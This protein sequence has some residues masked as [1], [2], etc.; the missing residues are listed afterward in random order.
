MLNQVPGVSHVDRAAL[1]HVRIANWHGTIVE[2][3]LDQIGV[4]VE[5]DVGV[6]IQVAAFLAETEQR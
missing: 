6:T 3:V 5:I 1:V 2:H 4:V